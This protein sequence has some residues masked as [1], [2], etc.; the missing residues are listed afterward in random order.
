MDC[1]A[2]GDDIAIGVAHPLTCEVRAATNLTSSRAIQYAGGV[3][4]V[5]CVMS[6]GTFDPYSSKL[7][8]NLMSLRNE[9]N[10]KFYVWVLPVNIT[11]STVVKSVAQKHSDYTVSFT[12][13][14]DGITPSD[15]NNL[16]GSIL[17]STNN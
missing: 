5:Y 11:A 13:G 10:C 15:Y 2:I 1:V 16:A 8:T 12:P 4:H 6:A 3:Y 14:V 9:S 17:N 7:S